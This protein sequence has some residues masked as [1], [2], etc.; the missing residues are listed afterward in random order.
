MFSPQRLELARKRR[1]YTGTTLAEKAGVTPVTLSRAVNSKQSPDETT[2]AALAKVLRYPKAFFFAGDIDPI[3]P[4]AASFRSLKAMTARERDAAVAAGSLAYLVCD[5][6][7]ARYQLPDAELLDLEHAPEP[8]AAARALRN[9]WS[10]GEKPVGNMIKLLETKGVRV[11]SLAENSKNVDA[12]SCWRD[13]EPYVFL[14]TFKSTERSR[15]DAAHELGHLVLH[16]HGGARQGK[17]SEAEANAFASA[18]LMPEAD[19]KATIPFVGRLQEI[20]TAKRR[21]GTSVMAVT[22]R[23]HKLGLL[24]DWQYRNFCI[25]INRTYGRD[26]PESLPPERSGVWQMVLTDLWKQGT[27]KGH[28]AADLH[29]PEDE[30]E[31]LL[32][33]LAGETSPPVRSGG[34]PTLRAVS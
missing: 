5:W 1:R 29:L 4:S 18:F 25:N 7:N 23:I 12:F 9:H 3:D 14:N 21:W 11:F 28:I 16:K 19:V 20:V 24:S 22:Y 15:F 13:G 17:N 31:N 2:I 34:R 30:I 8:A 6:V 26:E 27:T 32:F 33:G 10:M